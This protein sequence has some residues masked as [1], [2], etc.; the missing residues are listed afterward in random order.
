MW[1]SS[2]YRYFRYW[3]STYSGLLY[4]SVSLIRHHNYNY[5]LSAYCYKRMNIMNR[6][7]KHSTYCTLLFTVRTIV[8]LAQYILYCTLH[9]T[10][11][12]ASVRWRTSKVAGE[13]IF[14]PS[15]SMSQMWRRYRWYWLILTP[16][17]WIIPNT[18]ELSYCSTT[19]TTITAMDYNAFVDASTKILVSTLGPIVDYLESLSYLGVNSHFVKIEVLV[20]KL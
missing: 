10:Y 2:T 17:L 18:R 15:S 14:C 13:L 19:S 5:H 1:H 9:S 4:P 11:L 16:G 6:L 3:F 12:H 20:S 8:S 7:R